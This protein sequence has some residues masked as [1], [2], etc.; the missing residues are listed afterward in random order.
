MVKE[1][2]VSVIISAFNA[3][4]TIEKSVESI[5]DQSYKNLEILVSDDC[6]TDNTYEMLMKMNSKDE[7]IVVIKNQKNLGLTKSLNNLLN[8][9]RGEYIARHDA[10]D[11]S[12]K[13]RIERQ[14][15]YLLEKNFDAVCC[16][17]KIIG[18]ERIIPNI[19]KFVNPKFV[20]KIKNP[21]IHG[22]LLIKREII[23][24]VGNY[25]ERFLFSQDYKLFKDLFAQ[26]YKIKNLKE[27]LYFLNMKNNIST[28]FK[29][30]QK[31]F[32]D[33]VRK[34]LIP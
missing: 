20:M 29:I 19:S 23:Q 8:L 17:A 7:R 27:V 32:A 16:L 28:K 30:E 4:N 18:E 6:S 22:T 26:G 5:S 21:F 25:D 10:D 24:S 3:E 9:A 12:K 1:P 34:N 14:L 13:I 33:C 2:L 11:I 31:Y 15:N